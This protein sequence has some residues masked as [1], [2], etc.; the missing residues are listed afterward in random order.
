MTAGGIV[1]DPSIPL[2]FPQLGNLYQT[3]SPW[4]EAALR[5]TAGLALIPHGLRN[6]FGMFPST[7]VRA[8]NLNELAK[9]LDVVL[10][11]SNVVHLAGTEQIVGTSMVARVE[12]GPEVV[13]ASLS[14]RD[15]TVCC[16]E[17]PIP[18]DRPLCLFKCADKG[19]AQVGDVV[20]FTLRYSNVGGRPIRSC[21]VKR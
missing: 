19:S 15:L 21:S 5:V 16:N 6:T 17:E 18:P 3:L 1:P 4:A 9:Q 7:G 20:T 12:N 2:I 14:T 13:S 8:H 10:Q 11:F